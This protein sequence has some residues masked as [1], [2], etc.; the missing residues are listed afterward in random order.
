MMKS[1]NDFVSATEG[2]SAESR[3]VEVLSQKR[4]SITFL[5]NQKNSLFDHILVGHEKSR[6]ALQISGV[7]F[8][9]VLHKMY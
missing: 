4:P 9:C 8:S 5:N 2:V 6:S 1:Y 7:R 3:L